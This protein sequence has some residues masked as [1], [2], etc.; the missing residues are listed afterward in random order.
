MAILIQ[1][2][3]ESLIIE[4]FRGQRVVILM[5]RTRESLIIELIRGLKG[6]HFDTAHE[7]VLDY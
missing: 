2:I 1:H 7:Q 6:S 4:E 3:S 5:Q